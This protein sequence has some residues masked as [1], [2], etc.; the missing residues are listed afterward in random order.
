MRRVGGGGGGAEGAGVVF[1]NIE[2]VG[3]RSSRYFTGMDRVD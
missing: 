1:S 2:G 3:Y